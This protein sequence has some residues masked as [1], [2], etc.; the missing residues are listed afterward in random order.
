MA[1]KSSYKVGN[2]STPV[3]L[4][5]TNDVNEVVV[6]SIFLY[7]SGTAV[8]TVEFQINDTTVYKVDVDAGASVKLADKINL[9]TSSTLDVVAG[10][11]VNITCNYLLQ[12]ADVVSVNSTVQTVVD[13]K[14][15]IDVLY[16]DKSNLDAVAADLN[17]IDKAIVYADSAKASANYKG[18]W[19]DTYIDGYAVGDSVTFNGR[20][21]V[22]KIDA[23]TASPVDFTSDANWKFNQDS[24]YKYVEESDD[25]TASVFDYVLADTT[26]AAFTVTLPASPANFDIVGFMDVKDSFDT[27]NVTVARNGNLIVGL[28]E[29][30]T[31]DKKGLSMELMFVNG[32]WRVR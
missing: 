32:D 9:N 27:N 29:D 15:S 11:A 16:A 4:V 24:A 21:Y 25:Y 18:D 7:N 2:D 1:F 3:N 5:T 12:A 17:N 6:Y 19:N 22:S 31:L 23:N 10:T 30:L 20:T 14:P 26:S 13:L 8:E 28:D